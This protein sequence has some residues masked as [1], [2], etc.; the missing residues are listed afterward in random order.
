MAVVNHRSRIVYVILPK[1]ACTSIMTLF[2]V[3]DGGVVPPGP[4]SPSRL[5]RLFGRKPEKPFSIHQIAGYLTT[6]F[7]ATEPVPEGYSRVCTVRDPLSR[8]H[9]AWSNKVGVRARGSERPGLEAAGLPTDPTFGEFI[10]N[11]RRYRK[12]SRP[13]RIHTMPLAWHLGPSL[14]WYDHVFQLEDLARFEGYVSERIGGEPV[15]VPRENKSNAAPRRLGFGQR[16]VDRTRD[17]LAPDYALLADRYQFDRSL[18]VF[19]RKH[20]LTS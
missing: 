7:I 15:R 19:M 13:A 6:E 2:F 3:L 9:S 8:L 14:I 18:E 20:H 11:Y 4:A 1:A 12:V 16:Q 10:D 5:A 17:I